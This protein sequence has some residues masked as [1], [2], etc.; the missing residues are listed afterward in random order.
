MVYSNSRLALMLDYVSQVMFDKRNTKI[1]YQRRD[2]LAFIC[3][4]Q[5]HLPVIITRMMEN[6]YD[7]EYLPHVHESSFHAIELVNE[8]DWGWQAITT[9]PN[10]RVM[11]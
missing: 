7:W 5:R 10:S 1:N 3:C 11:Q 6:A 8:G 9:Q 2:T 4:Y